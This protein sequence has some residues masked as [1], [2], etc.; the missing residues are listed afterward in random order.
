MGFIFLKFFMSESRS[1]MLSGSP[2]S[3][4]ARG[5]A[6]ELLQAARGHVS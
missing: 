5:H 6:E 4:T 3:D 1:R 2:D